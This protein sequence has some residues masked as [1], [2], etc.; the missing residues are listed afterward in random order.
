MIV[1]SVNTEE[2][3]QKL[4]EVSSYIDE[5]EMCII[6]EHEEYPEL[7]EWVN[8]L[9][10]NLDDKEPK[11]VPELYISQTHHNSFHHAELTDATTDAFYLK[12]KV[13]DLKKIYEAFT[14]AVSTMQ[15][16]SSFML[17]DT[18]A[19]KSI[20]SETWLSEL[21]WIPI[22]TRQLPPTIKPFRFAGNPVPP[23]QLAC[24]LAKII[25]INGKTNYLRQVVF[26]LPWIPF[27]FLLGLQTQRA[28]RFD[29][30]LRQ[31]SGSHV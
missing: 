17:I 29:L 14:H 28:L 25:D 26:I 18:G 12:F 19:P 27:P 4:D 5:D 11:N 1:T 15:K 21:K 7:S 30:C 3:D 13:E 16:I 23:Q 24:L 22:Q 20:C 8:L 9:L 31:E 10:Q 2:E 6:D